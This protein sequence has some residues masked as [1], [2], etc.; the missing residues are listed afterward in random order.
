[1]NDIKDYTTKEKFEISLSAARMLIS[2]IIN[3]GKK[4]G[5]ARRLDEHLDIVEE[6]FNKLQIEYKDIYRATRVLAKA[7]EEGEMSWS[8]IEKEISLHRKYLKKIKEKN[9]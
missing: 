2:D 4:E 7:M 9:G 3:Y 5:D 8:D 6:M 1:M